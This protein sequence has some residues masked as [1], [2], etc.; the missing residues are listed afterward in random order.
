VN[1][2]TSKDESLL[3]AV[4]SLIQVLAPEVLQR[5]VDGQK[6]QLGMEHSTDRQADADVFRKFLFP[7]SSEDRADSFLDLFL[8]AT[9]LSV[10]LTNSNGVAVDQIVNKEKSVDWAVTVLH[11]S[12]N[13]KL[14]LKLMEC[15]DEGHRV[16]SFHS[17]KHGNSSELL[18]LE[19]SLRH[20][21]HSSDNHVVG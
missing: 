20:R 8:Q 16:V 1:Y 19:C 9:K 4:F 10:S 15:R 14:K 21:D 6:E 3:G 17:F 11:L 2:L 7:R 18:P 13:L 12:F 5:L